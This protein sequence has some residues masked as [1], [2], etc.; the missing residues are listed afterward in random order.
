MRIEIKGG[1]AG[2]MMLKENAGVQKLKPNAK[3]SAPPFSESLKQAALA[4]MCH[5]VAIV[6]NTL[7]DS[8]K[9]AVPVLGC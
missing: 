4:Q 5:R 6:R 8:F 2:R 3:L 7:P 1:G 9:R